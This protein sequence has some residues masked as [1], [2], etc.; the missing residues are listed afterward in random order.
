ML[1]N[2]VTGRKSEDPLEVG[3]LSP[4][5]ASVG[6]D[7]LFVRWQQG[8]DQ[9]ARA[10]LVDRFM[11]LARKLARRYAG[12]EPFDDLLQVASIGL[13]KAIDRFD[14]GHGAAFSSF[15]V[16]TIL[17]E[18]KRHFRDTG[19][20]VHV[21]R[22]AQELA[23]KVQEAQECLSARSERSPTVQE[24]AHYMEI[25][26]EEVVDALEAGAAH[27]STPLDA[28]V[29]RKDGERATLADTFGAEDDRFELIDARV[30]L[31]AVAGELSERERL[32]L[33]LYFLEERT[34]SQIAEE[35]GVSQMQVSRILRRAVERLR[36]LTEHD[37]APSRAR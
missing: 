11:P 1:E 5:V 20:F 33:T 13:L 26:V 31:G 27:H 16:P 30:T 18:L 17:G 7:A 24:L 29:G 15:A 3:P 8:C 6:M 22:R 4:R 32:V 12:L 21:P 35:L 19:W 34:Q 10:E 9:R 28:P 25:S 2:A 23:L 37:A 36:E 14:P